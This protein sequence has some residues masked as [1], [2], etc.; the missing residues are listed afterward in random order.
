MT[1]RADELAQTNRIALSAKMVRAAVVHNFGNIGRMVTCSGAVPGTSLQ[2]K[3]IPHI[4]HG[5]FPISTIAAPSSVLESGFASEMSTPAGTYETF[6]FAQCRNGPESGFGHRVEPWA[7][8]HGK[9]CWQ[10]CPGRPDLSAP[11]TPD[12]TVSTCLQISNSNRH[13]RC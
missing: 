3:M 2:S 13:S 9:L 4:L 5:R 10:P 6:S 8:K 7:I 11:G 12:R 1:T